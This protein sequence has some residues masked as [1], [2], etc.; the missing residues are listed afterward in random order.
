MASFAFIHSFHRLLTTTQPP[1]LPSLLS[2]PASFALFSLSLSLSPLF[3][4]FYY[5]VISTKKLPN[6]AHKNSLL[7]R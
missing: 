3:P 1:P 2:L 4:S 5:S 6:D 7:P